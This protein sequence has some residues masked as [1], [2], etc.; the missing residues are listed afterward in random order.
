MKLTAKTL[1]FSGVLLSAITILLNFF[2]HKVIY[3]EIIP[4]ALMPLLAGL[5]DL[6]VENDKTASDSTLRY[7]SILKLCLIILIMFGIEIIAIGVLGSKQ[8][9][10]IWLLV[11]AYLYCFILNAHLLSKAIKELK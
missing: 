9:Q 2:S 11:L 4:F 10:H 3:I 1:L 8:F 5:V 6:K 7:Q